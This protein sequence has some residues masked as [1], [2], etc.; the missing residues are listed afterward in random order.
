MIEQQD[1]CQRMEE[2]IQFHTAHV[3]QKQLLWRHMFRTILW[4]VKAHG[5]ATHQQNDNPNF[6]TIKYY[7]HIFY[8]T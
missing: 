8:N 1:E 5:C 7:R 4:L 6:T 3:R 2:K